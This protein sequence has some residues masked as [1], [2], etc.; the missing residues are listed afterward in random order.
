[1]KCTIIDIPEREYRGIPCPSVTDV[2]RYSQSGSDWEYVKLSKF[3]DEQNASVFSEDDL[4]EAMIVGSLYDR[5]LTDGQ[6]PEMVISSVKTYGAKKFS[7]EQEELSQ[8]NPNAVLVTER[9]AS[10]VTGMVNSTLEHPE[11]MEYIKA[12]RKQVKVVMSDDNNTPVLRGMIDL[13]HEEQLSLAD[14]KTYSRGNE[15]R[16]IITRRGYDMQVAAY[17]GLLSLATGKSISDVRIICVSQHYPH[18]ID[19]FILSQEA[20]SGASERFATAF[21]GLRNINPKKRK[22]WQTL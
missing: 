18:D 1:M 20:L 12:S 3:S 11:V 9:V 22:T 5:F 2:V 17:A 6:A 15:P 14:L 16:G 21:Q 10:R 4:S 19:L 7:E 13:F 8:S